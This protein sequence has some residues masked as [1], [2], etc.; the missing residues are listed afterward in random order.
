MSGKGGMVRRTAKWWTIAGAAVAIVLVGW[1]AVLPRLTTFRDMRGAAPSRAA[2]SSMNTV[3]TLDQG[4]YTATGS[5]DSEP[6]LAALVL[7]QD[8][9]VSLVD[10]RSIHDG[11]TAPIAVAVS[12]DRQASLFAVRADDGR[13]WFIYVNHRLTFPSP[14]PGTPSEPGTYYGGTGVVHGSNRT[15]SVT[16]G[17]EGTGGNTFSGWSKSGFPS[18]NLL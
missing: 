10:G 2:Q 5:L 17:P 6:A 3:V 9:G 13:C 16:P 14:F 4:Q 1:L 15:C 8:P 11:I 12:A 18:K 7:E